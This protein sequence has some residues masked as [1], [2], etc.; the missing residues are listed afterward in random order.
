MTSSAGNYAAD[1]QA[2]APSNIMVDIETLGTG[3]DAMIVAIAACTFHPYNNEIINSF[4]QA[5]DLEADDKILKTRSID[6]STVKWWM[7]EDKAPARKL[8]FED[9]KAVPLTQA[10]KEFISWFNMN[11][12]GRQSTMVWANDPDFDC[13]ILQNAIESGNLELPWAF[14]NCRSVRTMKDMGRRLGVKLPLRTNAH[15]ALEDCYY[16]TAIVQGVFREQRELRNFK[17][18]HSGR[19]VITD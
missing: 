4:Y 11:T 14:W 1:A 2:A 6:P 10:L 13:K 19:P 7:Q 17:N 5:V 8:T 12:M 3:A 18:D 16:Q 9:P 15:Y